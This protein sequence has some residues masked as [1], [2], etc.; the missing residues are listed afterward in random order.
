MGGD[1]AARDAFHLMDQSIPYQDARSLQQGAQDDVEPTPGHFLHD[2]R[3]K[4]RL[5]RRSKG[6]TLKVA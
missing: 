2:L 5:V 1:V 4:I 3:A 6:I